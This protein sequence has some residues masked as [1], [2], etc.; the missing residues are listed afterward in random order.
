MKPPLQCLYCGDKMSNSPKEKFRNAA[1]PD[2]LGCC[3]CSRRCAEE[4]YWEI[5]NPKALQE[6]NEALNKSHEY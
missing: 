3:Y 1:T 4:A 6:I 5:D 2:E